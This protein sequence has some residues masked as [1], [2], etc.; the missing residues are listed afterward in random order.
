MCDTFCAL[1]EVTRNRSVILAKSSDCE[2]NEAQYIYRVRARKPSKGELIRAAHIVIPQVDTTYEAVISRSFW[3]WGGELGINEHGLAVGNE[4][5]YSNA[6]AERDGLVV[7]DMLRLALERAS[8][9]EQGVETIGALVHEHGQGGNCELRGNS[10]FDGSYILA[11]RSEA[12]VLETAGTEWAARRISAFDSISNVMTIRSD[13]DLC[14]LADTDERFD[15]AVEFQDEASMNRVAA[16]ERRA[17]SLG[18]LE[19][20]A[21]DITVETMFQILRQHHRDYH[22]SMGDRQTNICVHAGP[23]EDRLW[24]ATG[25]MVTEVDETSEI[26]WWT[27]SSST[28]LSIFKPVFLG[29]GLPDMGPWPNEHYDPDSMYWRHERLHRRA[30]LDFDRLVPEIREDFDAIETT[31]LEEADT[32]KA[33]SAGEKAAFSEH[34]FLVAREAT[35]RWIERVEKKSWAYPATPFGA[36]WEQLNRAA[37]FTL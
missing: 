23:F 33:S 20:S 19:K 14:S 24:Q 37:A 12:W 15:F 10:H 17:C 35:D 26:S 21:G 1:P 25:A 3:T 31:F 29:V 32:V 22:P 9:A 8:S 27:G 2:V 16:R 4:A 11:D 7:T 34:C 28:C 36:F 6:V 18:Y 30:I 13:W 5:V